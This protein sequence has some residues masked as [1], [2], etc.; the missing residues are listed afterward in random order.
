MIAYISNL[1]QNCFNLFFFFSSEAIKLPGA[2]LWEHYPTVFDES[3]F[4]I[5]WWT[6]YRWEGTGPWWILKR[7]KMRHWRTTGWASC[8]EQLENQE[9][10]LCT[11]KCFHLFFL[12]T[13]Q[14]KSQGSIFVR[15]H[16]PWQVLAREAEFLKIKVPTKKVWACFSWVVGLLRAGW[17]QIVWE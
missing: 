1:F 13:L 5:D 11:Y 4:G 6:G 14:N 15:I 10:K 17:M 12:C 8:V 3:V 16:A 7:T 2:T 9:F